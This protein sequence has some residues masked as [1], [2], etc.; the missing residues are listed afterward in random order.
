MS[1]TT[2]ATDA[3]F[4][5]PET[6]SIELNQQLAFTLWSLWKHRNLR[7]WDVVT[8]A[9]ATVVERARNLFVDWQLDNVRAAIVPSPQHQVQQPIDEGIS[10]A[11]L[12]PCGSLASAISSGWQHLCLVGITVTLMSL[13]FLTSTVSSLVFVF[14]TLKVRL[15]W[16]RLLVTHVFIQLMLVKLW[17]CTLLCRT[18]YLLMR[19]WWK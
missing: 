16:P 8:E 1:S 13:S 14:E 4:S 19:N 6:L 3:I 7:V 2:L 18:N 15:F 10:A 12:Y 9:S 11:I 17:N 5:L